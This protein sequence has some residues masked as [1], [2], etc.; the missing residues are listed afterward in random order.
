MTMRDTLTFAAL[1][2]AN[3]ARQA[4]WCP[5]LSKAGGKS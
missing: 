4:E 5:D 2:Q 1:R 3:A